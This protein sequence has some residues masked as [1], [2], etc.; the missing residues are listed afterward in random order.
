MPKDLDVYRDWLG[1]TDTE[2]PLNYYQLL[3]LKKFEDD[4]EKIRSNYR[5]LNAQARKYAAGKFGDQSQQL[6]NELAKAMLCLTDAKRKAEYDASL[7]R[8]EE[9]KLGRTLEEILIRRKVVDSAQLAKARNY[10]SAVGVEIC[11]AL[12]QQKLVVV[13]RPL[14]VGDAEPVAIDVEIFGHNNSCLRSRRPDW[15]PNPKYEARNP[16]QGRNPKH[17]DRND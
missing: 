5:K 11:E 12:V 10:A 17:E 2:R 3:R 7:G 6:L 14:G 15:A 8:K 16:K 9:A 1:I 4:T 13:Q